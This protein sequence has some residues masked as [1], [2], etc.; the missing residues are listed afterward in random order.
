ML[1]LLKLSSICDAYVDEA[2]GAVAK[3]EGLNKDTE[4][5]SFEKLFYPLVPSSAP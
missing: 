3:G 1:D 5:C 2:T 4:I